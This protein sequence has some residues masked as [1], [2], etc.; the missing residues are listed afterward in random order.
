MLQGNR[1]C[2]QNGK[3]VDETVM[4]CG[5]GHVVSVS[6]IRTP[7]HNQGCH[8]YNGTKDGTGNKHEPYTYCTTRNTKKKPK[9]RW[10]WCLL[11]HRSVF[12]LFYFHVLFI[13]K[14]SILSDGFDW[15]CLAD[16]KKGHSAKPTNRQHD[17]TFQLP[18]TLLEVR[19]PLLM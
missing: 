13:R 2:P 17:P 3:V 12:L 7:R 15:H 8:Y 4:E 5:G 10:C 19:I 1:S 14:K 18:I 11:G 16:I 6:I 9:R